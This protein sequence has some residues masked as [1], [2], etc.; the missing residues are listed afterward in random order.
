MSFPT[1]QILACLQHSN[2]FILYLFHSLVAKLGCLIRGRGEK[3]GSTKKII[4]I[5]SNNVIIVGGIQFNL[6]LQVV[7]SPSIR[8]QLS[9][10]HHTI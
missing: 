9:F 6:F 5:L 8:V 10:D 7:N 3:N 1:R 2:L 4:N